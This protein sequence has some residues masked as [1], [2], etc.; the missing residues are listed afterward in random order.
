MFLVAK[1]VFP[2]GK[3]CE[4]NVF[5][6]F[7]TEIGAG[8]EVKLLLT[9]SSFYQVWVNE[10]FVSFGPARTAKGYARVDELSLDEYLDLPQN[11]LLITVAGYYCRS[12]STVLQPSF[13]QAEVRCGEAVLSA[14]GREFEAY[15]P[16]VKQQRVKRYSVQRHFSEV[17]DWRKN[18][19]LCD[20]M[21]RTEIE[22]LADAPQPIPRR[23]PYP[24]Y[25]DI[26]LTSAASVG[27]LTFD[28]S[29]PYRTAPY[30]FLPDARWGIFDEEEITHRPFEW[31]QRQRQCKTRGKTELPLT[32]GENEYAILDF[33]RIEM[34]LIRL[35]ADF[36]EETELVIGFSEDASPDCFAF[37][38]MNVYNAVELLADCGKSLHFTSFE[39]YVGR[40]FIVAVRR[41]RM[42]LRSF[43]IKTFMHA[44]YP[45]L[46]KAPEDG[47]LCAIFEGALRTFC[48]NA[49]DLYTDCPSRE[50]AGW[51][52]DSY[53][54]AKTEYA[55]F[56]NTLVEDAFLENYRLYENGGEFPAGALP[57]CYP[58]DEQNDRK[59]IPQWTMWY[60]L[61]VE[62]YVNCRGHRGDA[63][64]FRK[65]VEGL[66][67][68]YEQYENEDGLLERL[69]SW[70]FVEWSR[71]NTWTEDVNYPTNFLY[72]AV[73]SAAY[74]LYGDRTLFEK[75]EA[76]RKK[77]IAQSFD[78]TRFYDHA[79]RNGEGKLIL[80][81]DCSE[82]AQYYAILFGGF[83]I[84][85][86]AHAP[87]YRLVTEVCDA[88]N[89]DFPSD[90]EPINAFIGV[91]LRLEA[92]LKIKAYDLVLRDVRAFFGGMTA[93]TGTLWEYRQRKGSRDHGFASYALVAILRALER[94]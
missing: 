71:A 35:D 56:G 39:P 17:W 83:D 28:E 48:H 64:L 60:I 76:V 29:L 46:P 11:E 5:A 49:V 78:G 33:S 34:G 82:I 79:I 52:C 21:T 81:G 47:E 90:M 24:Y 57:M 89:P 40:Y 6:V 53:F 30:S 80:Q 41:G 62:E 22:V 65:T 37:T 20:P 42:T 13:L 16:T 88:K 32:L 61:E 45:I 3:S 93:E 44:P 43:G 9:A 51:L 59:F 10:R 92:L 72:A 84:T 38:N 86:S 87:F 14:T 26:S 12:L 91:Y 18:A 67:A 25:E 15:L 27:R 73:L 69:P 70:N 36:D 55:I 58:A 8:K 63:E 77:A 68:F 85:D 1:P 4:K 54:T 74:R 94:E 23:A 50:R 2:V 75:S 66:L 19:S 7:R 31:L